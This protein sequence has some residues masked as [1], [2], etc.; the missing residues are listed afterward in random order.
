MRAW[1][2]I[3]H[4][5]TAHEVVLLSYVASREQAARVHEVE[6][7]CRVI[8]VPFRATDRA[9]GV[10][11][12]LATGRPF[13]AHLFESA[14]MTRHIAELLPQTDVIHCNTLRVAGNLP[15]TFE[16]KLV[17]D[18]I[19][20]LSL[21]FARRA[22]I[23]PLPLRLMLKGEARRLRI[24]EKELAVRAACPEARLRLVGATPSARVRALA[25]DAIEVTDYV[26]DIAA[27]LQRAKVAAAP[28][29]SGAGVKTKILEAMG[30]ATPVVAT[31]MANTGIDA[32]DEEEILL[33]DAPET[34]AEKIVS[35][36]TDEALAARIGMA[37]R[38]RAETRFS[39][40]VTGKKLLELYEGLSTRRV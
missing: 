25:S 2:F 39:T 18:F 27:E 30:C 10:F 19:D 21:S 16:A 32:A 6:R 9:L 20:A 7:V 29:R 4:L 37:G 13:Q 33:A 38:K 40:A 12:G 35:L 17:V 1:Q 3:R 23:S 15:Q 26:P 5:A 36:L 22:A 34:F 24:F 31:P 14:A 8:A 11:G 28:L